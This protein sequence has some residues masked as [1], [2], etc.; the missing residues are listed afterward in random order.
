MVAIVRIAKYI[1]IL[2]EFLKLT[3]TESPKNMIKVS[4]GKIA[5][6]ILNAA[7]NSP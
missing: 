5:G 4:R 2:S 6:Y 3:K 1:L 7:T